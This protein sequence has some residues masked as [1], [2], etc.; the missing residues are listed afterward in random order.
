[1]VPIAIKFAYIMCIS[2]TILRLFVHKISFIFNT[3]SHFALDAVSVEQNC[4][5]VETLL[6]R[7]VS[8]RRRQQKDVL[9]VQ[10]SEDKMKEVGVC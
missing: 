10:P 6:A 7:Y 4:W 9:S 8:A 2:F 1:M 3:F 5:S